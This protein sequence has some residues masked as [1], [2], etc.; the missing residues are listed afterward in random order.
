MML[1]GWTGEQWAFAMYF[2][3]TA[4]STIEEAVAVQVWYKYNNIQPVTDFDWPDEWVHDVYKEI[5]LDLFKNCAGGC[6]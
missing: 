6:V 2:L 1:L 5:V 3:R 4:P